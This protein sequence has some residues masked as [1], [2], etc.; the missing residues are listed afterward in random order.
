MT[1]FSRFVAVAVFAGLTAS[2]ALAEN[3]TKFLWTKITPLRGHTI[4]E[5]CTV[6]FGKSFVF[7][8]RPGKGNTIHCKVRFEAALD[9]QRSNNF[10]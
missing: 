10:K 9:G 3:F 2:P 8:V 4:L 6:R 5:S 1:F 7:G